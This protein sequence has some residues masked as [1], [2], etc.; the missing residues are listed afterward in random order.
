MEGRVLAL[1]TADACWSKIFIVSGKASNM[2]TILEIIADTSSP[3]E[4]LLVLCPSWTMEKIEG[5][6][7]LSAV[8]YG[9]LCILSAAA[10]LVGISSLSSEPWALC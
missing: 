10:A 4:H 2:T 3:A 6:S 1:G 5:L 8:A 9:A 7:H